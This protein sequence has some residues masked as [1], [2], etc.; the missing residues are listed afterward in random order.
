MR[1]LHRF[2]V[3]LTAFIFF[4]PFVCSQLDDCPL[5]QTDC[6]GKCGAYIDRDGDVVCDH[7][8]LTDTEKNAGIPVDVAVAASSENLAEKAIVSVNPVGKYNLIPLAATIIAAYAISSIL[9]IKGHITCASHRRFWNA[10]LAVTFVVSCLLGFILILRL[11]Y[12][13]DIAL[14]FN[15]LFWHV[16]AGIIM[17]VISFFHLYWHKDYYLAIFRIRSID[18]CNN[19]SIPRKKR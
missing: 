14:P 1:F 6:I 8:I 5:E 18:T 10:L 4:I 3:L 19:A 16:E 17:A 2:C 15:M 7:S 12:G 11:D 13:A 9:Y